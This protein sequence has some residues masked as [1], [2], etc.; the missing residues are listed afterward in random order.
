LFTAN[1]RLE[2]VSIFKGGREKFIIPI[3]TPAPGNHVL[4]LELS[5][6]GALTEMNGGRRKDTSLDLRGSSADLEAIVAEV[7]VV[8]PV[9]EL[10]TMLNSSPTLLGKSD[11]ELNHV[12]RLSVRELGVVALVVVNDKDVQGHVDWALADLLGHPDDRK[13]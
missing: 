7:R 10:H 4:W 9:E 13:S 11:G 5:L 1:L 8:G 2:S 3:K 12:G 6:L